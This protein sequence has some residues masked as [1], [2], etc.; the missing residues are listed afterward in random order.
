MFDKD[1]HEL[2]SIYEPNPGESLFGCIIVCL[3]LESSRRDN[4]ALTTY[5]NLLAQLQ[6]ISMADP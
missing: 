5:G 2:M 1:V 3:F 6:Y 4:C